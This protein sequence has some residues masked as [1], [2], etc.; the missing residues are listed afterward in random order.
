M[1]GPDYTKNT[2]AAVA[3]WNRLSLLVRAAV[4]Y[5]EAGQSQG[6]VRCRPDWW[7]KYEQKL[8]SAVTAFKEAL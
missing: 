8:E 4:E 7:S 6:V 1:S 3:S 2:E 5:V